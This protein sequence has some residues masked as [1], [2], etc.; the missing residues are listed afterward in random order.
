[1]CAPADISMY[2]FSFP[3]VML[4]YIPVKQIFG[5]FNSS[6]PRCHSHSSNHLIKPILEIG[7]I[8]ALVVEHKDFFLTK[9]IFILSNL[10]GLLHLTLYYQIWGGLLCL[11][12]VSSAD[13]IISGANSMPRRLSGVN[14]SSNQIG[15]LSFH[16]IFVIFGLNVHNNI[17]QKVVEVEFRLFAFGIFNGSLI[18]KNILK[19][20]ILEGF[21]HFL[22]K[23]VTW[24][25]GTWFTGILW[26]FSGV[27]QKWPLAVGQIF[28]PFF[29]QICQYMGFFYFLGKYPLGSPKT[30]FISSLELLL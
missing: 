30:W 3:L 5:H 8:K 1:M 2:M 15:S 28:G 14:V 16:P 4:N 13:D 12:F 24:D 20:G 23:F 29:N 17:V 21:G 9:F 19:L 11:S 25:N 6:V 27:C 7:W 10:G 26:V 22:K 18:T